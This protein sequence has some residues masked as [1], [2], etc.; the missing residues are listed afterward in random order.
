[1]GRRAIATNRTRLLATV[2]AVNLFFFFK[3]NVFWFAGMPG[4]RLV[5]FAVAAITAAWLWR[6]WWR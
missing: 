5:A 2:L 1:M 6:G 4:E 3:S